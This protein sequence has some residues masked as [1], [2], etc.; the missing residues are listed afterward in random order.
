[1]ERRLLLSL[2]L[3][4]VLLAAVLS[5]AA[6]SAVARKGGTLR[7]ARDTD[8][9]FVDPALASF[10][11]SWQIEFATCAK[12]FNYPDAAGVAGTRVV[13]E[14]V[15]RFTVSPSGKLYTFELKRTFRF[16][17]G[18][19]V[20]AGSF[21][22]AF[23]RDANPR[24]QSPAVAYLREIVGADA[25]IAGKAATISGVRVLGRYRLQI[26]LTKPLRDFTARLT[27]SFFCPLLPNAPVE[28]A[29]DDH[30]AGSGPYYVAERIPNRHVV[31]RRNRFYQGGR[32]ANADEIVMTIMGGEACRAAVEDGRIDYC[33][34]GISSA[35]YR[36]I[37]ATYGV[38]RPGG[39]FF[40]QP[41]L[42]T[43]YF[44]FN[45]DRPAFKGP[46]QIPLKKAINYAL[47]RPELAR[48]FG[49]LG[50]TR[51][52]QMLPA[53]LGHDAGVYSLKRA[54]TAT[55]R[56]WLARARVQPSALVLYAWNVPSGV[57]AAQ[58]FAFNLKQIGI[59]VEPKYFS[60]FVAS[61][62]A[63]TRGEPFDVAF[64]G[65][66]SDYADPAG[67][68][69]SLLDPNLRANANTN[70][71]YFRDSAVTARIEA[72]NRLEGA[73]RGNAWAA[74]DA[75]LMRNNP[76]WAPFAHQTTRN[77][78]SRSLGCVI[79]HP[80]YSGVDLAAACK[81]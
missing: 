52:D 80:V 65:W 11:W 43:V 34:G 1:M 60:P 35:A 32:P 71:S 30:P 18:A 45:H 51:T 66:G 56:K 24:M 41:R 68:F 33:Q 48:G 81:K 74:L 57:A 7:W 5:A 42:N 20:T 70:R 63:G 76:P 26:R 12:L 40:V 53:V 67:F 27:N 38:N 55:A 13:P 69:V 72:A 15:D 6:D 2:V 79:V 4:V 3:L 39:R 50:A 36:E 49:Y 9:D 8:V 46:G 29:G 28:P 61:E 77:F 64:V 47:D 31:L 16:H 23:N 62:K 44:A 54:D 21:A 78:V 73:A 22:E 75:D 14:V 19:P 58:V 59:D 37:A 10:V 17:T 25:V